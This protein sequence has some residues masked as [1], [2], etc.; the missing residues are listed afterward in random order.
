M[1]ASKTFKRRVII[2]NLYPIRGMD[3]CSNYSSFTRSQLLTESTLN[4]LL[5]CKQIYM[6]AFHVFYTSN[7]FYFPD[8]ELLYSF[9]KGIGY[10]RRQHVTMIVFVWRGPYAKEAFRLLKTC[11]RLKSVRFRMPCS[12]PPGYAAVREIRGLQQALVTHRLHYGIR[13]NDRHRLASENY[14][15]LCHRGEQ[16]KGPLDDVQ[17]LERAMMRPRL[18][19][20]A[21]DP[22]EEFDLFKGKREVLKKTEESSLLESSR[23]WY[24]TVWPRT[25]PF[26]LSG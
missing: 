23:S 25:H 5:S 16:R 12:E 6:E 24:R 10:N 7:R 26:S 20:Y 3:R 22:S 19:Q 4:I 15:C 17:E 9:L 18:K 1:T 21:E 2:Q 11:R 8:T 14:R 13:R